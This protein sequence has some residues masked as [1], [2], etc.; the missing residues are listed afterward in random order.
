MGKWKSLA[1]AQVGQF[2]HEKRWARRVCKTSVG[3]SAVKGREVLKHRKPRLL[4]PVAVPSGPQTCCSL[5]LFKILI[6]IDLTM[7]LPMFSIIESNSL[8][9]RVIL[10]ILS[11]M[12]YLSMCFA[13][14]KYPMN[15]A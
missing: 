14:C 8:K 3:S 15:F 5:Y 12:Q 10:I 4:L 7:C 6:S 11:H 9:A 1:L 13:R 2:T